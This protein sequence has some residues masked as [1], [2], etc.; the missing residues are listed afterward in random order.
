VDRR[1]MLAGIGALVALAVG[2]GAMFVL[3]PGHRVSADG[4]DKGVSV[5]TPSVSVPPSDWIRA[6][7][8]SYR[9]KRHRRHSPPSRRPRTLPAVMPGNVFVGVAVKGG[10]V[11]GV[12]TFS[13]A[14][15]ARIAMVEIYTGFGER[16]P[17]LALNQVASTGAT[18][19]I[20]WNPRGSSVARIA[21]GG[22]RSYLRHYAASAKRFGRQVVLSFGHEMNGTWNPWGAGHVSPSTFVTAW[23]RIHYV[24]AHAGVHNVTWSWDPSH[25]GALPRPWWPG[26]RY[27]DEIGI[28]GYQ[29]PG[30][31]FAKIFAG[32]IAD[33]RRF[34][35]K[36]I[37]IAE[38]AVA[39]G[40]DQARQII[41]LFNGVQ[42]YH[43]TGFVWFDIDHLEA[44]RLEGRP[45]AVRAFRSAVAQTSG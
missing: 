27:V 15:G 26:T 43:L 19:L 21:A 13:R 24:F 23:R 16:F 9:G 12:Q 4:R 25:V 28:D 7:P 34:T 17:W 44:W 14:T 36:P 10:I 11:S 42:Q 45:A 35:S 30:D 8:S 6:K 41:G 33:I 20:Q 40:A 5:A 31:T 32:P 22:Y 3:T 2:T 39:P 37:Y 1:S 18:P 29:R 38:T